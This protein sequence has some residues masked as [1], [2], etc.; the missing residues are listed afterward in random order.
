VG[1]SFLLVRSFLRPSECEEAEP[2]VTVNK[3]PIIVDDKLS[4]RLDF[5]INVPTALPWFQFYEVD[6]LRDAVRS[7]TIKLRPCVPETNGEAEECAYV[8]MTTSTLNATLCYVAV[9]CSPASRPLAIYAYWMLDAG[10]W[11]LDAGCWTLD[12]VRWL[13]G[14]WMLWS[15]CV[16]CPVGGRCKQRSRA[17]LSFARICGLADKLSRESCS[18]WAR[19]PPLLASAPLTFSLS[20]SLPFSLVI[21]PKK[22]SSETG[23]SLRQIAIPSSTT[24]AHEH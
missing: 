7:R 8:T 16:G 13:V 10:C 4:R 6:L 14:W 17:L 9:R 12:A 21:R 20:L 2:K 24:D 15:G 11:M 3:A 19:N 18:D 5:A 23:A 1:D 22:K